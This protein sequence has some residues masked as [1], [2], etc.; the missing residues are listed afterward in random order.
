MGLIFR[1]CEGRLHR[2]DRSAQDHHLVRILAAHQFIRHGIDAG[3]LEAGARLG[4]LQTQ[5]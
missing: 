2:A 4:E 3:A 1:A 5:L